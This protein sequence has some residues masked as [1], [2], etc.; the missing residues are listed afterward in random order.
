MILELFPEQKPLD[1]IIIGQQGHHVLK[2]EP[3]TI[4]QELCGVIDLGVDV[5]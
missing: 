3:L 1:G 4:A 5:V 2:E